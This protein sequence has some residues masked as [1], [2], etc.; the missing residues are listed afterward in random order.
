MIFLLVNCNS[1]TNRNTLTHTLELK[2]TIIISLDSLTKRNHRISYFSDELDLLYIYNE[3]IHEI[4]VFDISSLVQ[5]KSIKLAKEGPDEITSVE[6]IYTD[7][8]NIF[9]ILTKRGVIIEI[10]KDGVV[11]RKKQF[12]SRL[13]GDGSLV[14]KPRIFKV[15]STY[16]VTVRPNNTTKKNNYG[17]LAQGSFESEGVEYPFTYPSDLDILGWSTMINESRVVLLPSQNTF[18]VSF[19]FSPDIYSYNLTSGFAEKHKA[20]SSLM[21]APDKI[22]KTNDINYSSDYIMTNSWYL[23]LL[24]DKKNKIYYRLGNVGVDQI[25]G[26]FVSKNRGNIYHSLIILNDSFNVIGEFTGLNMPNNSFIN[27][28]LLYIPNNKKQKNNEDVMIYD[29]YQPL[30]SIN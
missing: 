22:I 9:T 28:G 15:D 4:Y 8:G 19:P 10:D 26:K 18:V 24:Y 5:R 27:D 6:S 7:N 12:L 17:F 16:F 30:S 20:S 23:N 29:I 13:N 1:N 3:L 11:L 14:N 25:N 21:E 2:D